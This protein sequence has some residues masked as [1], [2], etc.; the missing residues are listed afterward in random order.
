M[1]F[2]IYNSMAG[3]VCPYGLTIAYAENAVQNGAGSPSRSAVLSMDVKDGKIR[4]VLTNRG[5]IYPEIVINAAGVFA[6][7]VAEMAGDRFYS[8]HPRRGTNAIRIKRPEN[9]WAGS[10]PG[11]LLKKLP[12]IQKAEGLSIRLMIIFWVGWM[13]VETYG[14][15][16]FATQAFSIENNFKKQQGTVKELS[17]RYHLHI[18]PG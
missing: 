7:D 1:K 17:Q 3:S 15:E 11:K 14:K 16:N 4:S 5:R 9:L 2:A 13:Q 18:S 6:D 12:V 10:P 8:I